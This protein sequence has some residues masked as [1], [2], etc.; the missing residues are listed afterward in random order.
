[1][2]DGERE[3]VLLG[4]NL[5]L[6]AALVGTPFLPDLA[7]AVLFVEDVGEPPYRVDGLL[8]RLRLAGVLEK[9]GGLVYGAFTGA[10]PPPNRPSLHLDEVLAHYAGFVPGPVACRLVY[11]HF[12]RKSTLPVGVRARLDVSG[13][14]AS[15]TVLE[16]VAAP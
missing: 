10:E 5:S 3:G 15:L 16:P 13:P 7:G 6:I 12:P 14:W 4:G 11:G 2:Q 9:L 1:M 8:A